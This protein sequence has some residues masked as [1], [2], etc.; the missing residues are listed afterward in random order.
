[1]AYVHWGHWLSGCDA[2]VRGAIDTRLI[3]FLVEHWYQWLRGAAELRSPPMFYPV[4][5]ALAGWPPLP[6]QHLS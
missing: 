5:G 2:M 6:R 1:M 3:A 4:K